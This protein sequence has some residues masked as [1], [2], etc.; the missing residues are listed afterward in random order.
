MADVRSVRRVLVVD[1]EHEVRASFQRAFTRAGKGVFV[2]ADAATALRIAIAE[3]PDLAVVDLRLGGAWG[4]DLIK[5]L[6]THVPEAEIALVSAVVG[7]DA[8][9]EALHGFSNTY[10]QVL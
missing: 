8:A 1:D 9:L 5:E 2:A 6:Q 4:L 3:R 10:R 7:L